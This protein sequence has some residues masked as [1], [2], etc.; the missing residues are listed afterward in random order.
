MPAS[1]TAAAKVPPLKNLHTKLKSHIEIFKSISAFADILEGVTSVQQITVRV[2]K[3]DELWDKVNETLVDIENHDDYNPETSS[4]SQERLSFANTYYNLKGKFMDKIKELEDTAVPHQST[5]FMDSSLLPTVEHVKLPQIKLQTFSGDVDEWLSFRD[6]FLSLIHTK[7]DLPNVEKFHYLKGC[8]AGEAKALVDPL[9]ITAANYQVAWDTLMKRYNDSK[10][11]KRRQVR[12]LFNLPYVP[13]ESPALLQSLLEGFERSVQTLDQLVNTEDYKDLLLLEILGS[14]LDPSTRRAWE[15]FSASKEKDKVKDLTEFLQ[16]R[17]KVLSCLSSNET[18]T[19]RDQWQFNRRQPANRA[20]NSASNFT[21]NGCIA[22]SETH[23]L[24]QCSAFKELPVTE[25]DQLIRNH[26]MCRNCFRRGHI[27]LKCNSP[28]VCRNCKGK[29]HTLLCFQSEGR[30]AN[31]GFTEMPT[32][33]ENSQP[34]EPSSAAGTS[35]SY[36][37][38]RSNTSMLLATAVVLVDDCT[39]FSYP[40]RALLDSGSECNFMTE[41]VCQRLKLKRESTNISV[42]GIGQASSH[43]KHQVSVSIKSRFNNFCEEMEFLVLPKVTA[44]LPTVTIDASNW[45]LPPGIILADPSY[46][47]PTVVDLVLGIQHFFDFF[48]TGKKIP[49]GS[50][51]PTLT[52]SVFGWVVTGLVNNLGDSLHTTCNSAASLNLD[53]C[54]TRFWISEELEPPNTYS[55]NESRCE[56]QFV[57]TV[58][59]GADGRYTVTLPK[60]D[61]K[62]PNIGDSRDI[63]YRRLQGLER[64]LAKQPEICSQYMQFLSDYLELGHMRKAE[65]SLDRGRLR[66]FLPH[67]PVLKETSTTTKLRVVFDASCATSNGN[68]LNDILLAGPVIQDDLRS[69]IIRSRTK[70]YMIVAD[71]E[72]MFRQIKISEEDKPLQSILWRNERTEEVETYELTTVTYGTKPAPFL[73]TRVLKQLGIDEKMRYPK[74]SEV[75]VKDVYMDDVLT[76]TDDEAEAIR[77]Q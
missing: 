28:Y 59:R 62:F 5:R 10:I 33:L 4:V 43:V 7:A 49:L 20:G 19:K 76:G 15:E 63:A 9:S 17:V 40:V 16:T 26:N 51:L 31:P 29:H 72:K 61:N 42:V 36:T 64:R 27:A 38:R 71:I 48:Q 67:Q 6:L 57:R 34:I 46:C 58:R 22:C 77:I 74:A 70:Q 8:L 66:C 11:L 14:R 41:A 75:I 35:S 68:S 65:V 1:S 30:V 52:E 53:D 24:H 45:K 73:A 55:P 69:I 23:L 21:M 47:T 12:A 60:D 39:G 54:L 50:G 3:L 37:A 56:E 25:R 13:K 32:A 2:E 44:D 18:E